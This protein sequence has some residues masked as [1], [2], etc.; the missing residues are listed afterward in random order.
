L[1]VAKIAFKAIQV[2]EEAA[3]KNC[4]NF[5]ILPKAA[6]RGINAYF[7]TQRVILHANFT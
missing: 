2:E 6:K 5:I 1:E 4:A 7:I 3:A